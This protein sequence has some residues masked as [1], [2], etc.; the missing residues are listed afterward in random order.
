MSAK[1]NR[2]GVG[3]A[4]ARRSERLQ[5]GATQLRE[6]KR[7]DQIVIAAGL[8]PRARAIVDRALRAQDDDR[9]GHT[10]AAHL[11]DEAD[12][13][14]L[15]QHEIDDRRVVFFARGEREPVFTVRCPFDLVAFLAQAFGDELR[16]LLVVFDEQHAHASRLPFDA[17]DRYALRRAD[18]WR[19]QTRRCH[20]PKVD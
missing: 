19:E 16:N 5:M 18:A 15:G 6:R 2:A 20:A 3:V 12:A 4:T 8:Q 13:V 10:L 11:F 1:D 7:L 14:T 17:V 9:C